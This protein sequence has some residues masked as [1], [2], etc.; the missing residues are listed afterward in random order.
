[1][2]GLYDNGVAPTLAK[3]NAVILM[4][5]DQAEWDAFF[6]DDQFGYEHLINFAPVSRTMMQSLIASQVNIARPEGL[7]SEFDSSLKEILHLVS[8]AYGI[9]WPETFEFKKGS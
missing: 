3:A 4:T 6:S 8:R 5:A 1:M 9:L 2:D 7:A